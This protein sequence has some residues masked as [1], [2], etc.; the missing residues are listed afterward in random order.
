MRKQRIIN[1]EAERRLLAAYIHGLKGIV[2]QQ[3]QF[4]MTST[5]EQAVRLAVTTENVERP[6]QMREGPRNFYSSI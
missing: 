5:M 3:V 6:R 1:E 2:G 4:Q